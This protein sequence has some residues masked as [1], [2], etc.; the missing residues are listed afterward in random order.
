ML[1]GLPALKVDIVGAAFRAGRTLKALCMGLFIRKGTLFSVP[2]WQLSRRPTFT[3]SANQRLS[4]LLP[5]L[6]TNRI[7]INPYS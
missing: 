1:G 4:L 2:K 5:V 6:C 3:S 7:I